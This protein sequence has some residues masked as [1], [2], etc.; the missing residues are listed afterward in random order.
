MIRILFFVFLGIGSCLV[1]LGQQSVSP[2]V[3]DDIQVDVKDVML[4]EKGDTVTVDLFLI[5]YKKHPREF[6]LNT[7][8]SGIIGSEGRPS[9]YAT[10]QM[11]RVKVAVSDRQNYLNYLLEP[12][13]P[14][15]LQI[16]TGAWKK[17]WGKP[18]QL[19]LAFE[20]SEEEGK[21]LEVIVDLYR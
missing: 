11:G 14:V 20:D 15:A 21:F 18:K 5:S 13:E 19:I 3:I 12:D 2:L 4:S 6:K 8:A 1:A 17:Q 9:L 16:K 10:M 7:F